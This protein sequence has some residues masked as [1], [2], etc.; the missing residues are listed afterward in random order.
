MHF[1][2]FAFKHIAHLV[3]NG[4]V[5]AFAH[6]D[7]FPVQVGNSRF[8]LSCERM[9]ARNGN[10]DIVFAEQE[11]IAPLFVFLRAA[12]PDE[13]IKLSAERRERCEYACAVVLE[14]DDLD[15]KIVV[16]VTDARP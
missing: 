3:E 14:R 7:R 15:L 5:A 2:V 11:Q 6:H 12:R 8:F 1:G 9:G 16:A 10:A 4:R 13:K